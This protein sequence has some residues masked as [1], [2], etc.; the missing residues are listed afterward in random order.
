MSEICSLSV[1][2]QNYEV[3]RQLSETGIN[4]ESKQTTK[5]PE[6]LRLKMQDPENQGFKSYFSRTEDSRNQHEETQ[7]HENFAEGFQSF[8]QDTTLHGARFLFV[9]NVSRRVVWNIAM[10]SCFSFCAYQVSQSVRAFYRYPFHTTV[11]REAASQDSREPPFPAVT[12]CNL[13]PANTRRIRQLYSRVFH[14]TPTEEQLK[15]NIE[16]LSHLFARSPKVLTKEFKERNPEFFYRPNSPDEV[17]E[18]MKLYALLSHQIEEMLLPRGSTFESC[19]LNGEACGPKNFSKKPGI[20]YGQCYSFNS[21]KNGHPLLNVTLAGKDSGLKL[22]LNIER[23]SY[24]KNPVA[25]VGL[26]LLIHDQKAFPFTAGYGVIIQPGMSTV[27]AIKRKKV[28]FILGII[29]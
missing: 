10:V 23:E 17:E 18:A 9:S 15:Q 1:K 4:Q 19:S 5:K 14:V 21:G 6:I 20:S 2:S 28:S 12:L 26:T 29:R 16:D 8:T 3:E 27:C 25:S 22:R 7:E 13:N 11:K 24:L